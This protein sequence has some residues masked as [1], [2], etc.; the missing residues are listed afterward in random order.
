MEN[1]DLN[2]TY[3]EAI[4]EIEQILHSLREEQ[5]NIDTLAERVA[6]AT[7]LIAF[8]RKRLHDTEL[9]VKEIIEE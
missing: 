6:R 5:N 4:E 8:C 2:L 9:S 7:K 3:A 1:K